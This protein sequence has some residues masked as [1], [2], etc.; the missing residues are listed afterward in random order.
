MGKNIIFYFSGTGNSLKAAKDVASVLGDTELVFMKG[1]YVFTGTYERIGFVFPCYAA[2]APKVVIQFVKALALNAGS[3]NYTFSVVTC[4]DAGG[5]ALPMIQEQ[6]K[7]KGLALNYGGVVR[8]VGNYIVLYALP[9][10]QAERL[11]MAEEK[12]KNIAND[13]KRKAVTPIGKKRLAFSA[14]YAIGNQFFKTKEKQLTVS[15]DC[16]SCGLC[17]KIC[18]VGNIQIEKGKPV[19]LHKNCTN[20]FACVHWCPKQTINCGSVTAKR[21]RYHHPD[22][23]AEE[24]ITGKEIIV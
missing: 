14:F 22:V 6:L 20:C 10:N 13:I 5:N 1:S 12:M 23:T 8:V 16:T 15:D 7:K 11:R 18:P 24:I 9:E 2:G 3:T 21:G 19:F 17:A 4:N